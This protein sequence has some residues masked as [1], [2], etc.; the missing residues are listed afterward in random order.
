LGFWRK[1]SQGALQFLDLLLG[2]GASRGITLRCG[3]HFVDEGTDFYGLWNCRSA[4]YMLVE[5]V[6]GDGEQVGFGAADGLVIVDSQEAQEDF[7]DEIRY[8]GGLVA[9]AGRKKASQPLPMLL[10]DVGDERLFIGQCQAVVRRHTLSR[11]IRASVEE[12]WIP[13]RVRF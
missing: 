11:S 7:L 12:K 1:L 9:Q 4:H 6:K 3:F 13:G 8:V 10:F 2:F 5:D